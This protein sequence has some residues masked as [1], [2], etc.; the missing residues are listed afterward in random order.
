ME[1]RPECPYLYMRISARTRATR[2]I[3]AVA[4]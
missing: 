1:K 4:G 2:K 3:A